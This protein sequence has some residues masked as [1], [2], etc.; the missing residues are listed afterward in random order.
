MTTRTSTTSATM[1]WPARTR[2]LPKLSLP[3]PRTVDRPSDA[4]D[5]TDPD[6]DHIDTGDSLRA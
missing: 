4:T 5:R 2:V 3:V 1:N 6:P